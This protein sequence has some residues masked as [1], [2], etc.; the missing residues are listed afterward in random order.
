MEQRATWSRGKKQ[1][2]KSQS[3]VHS[4]TSTL[5]DLGQVMLPLKALATYKK[6][7]F[8]ALLNMYT[9]LTCLQINLMLSYL[10]WLK[11]PLAFC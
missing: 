9:S 2:H 10:P 8:L 11:A 6:E 4:P 3:C 7:R 5:G 1:N